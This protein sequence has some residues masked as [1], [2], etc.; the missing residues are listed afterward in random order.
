MWYCIVWWMVGSILKGHAVSIFRLEGL[1]GKM[2]AT[3]C[4]KTLHSHSCEDYKVSIWILSCVWCRVVWLLDETT[5]TPSVLELHLLCVLFG[6]HRP[7]WGPAAG[8]CLMS[9]LKRKSFCI[10]ECKCHSHWHMLACKY[11]FETK[12]CMAVAHCCCWLHAK[13]LAVPNSRAS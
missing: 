2:E 7:T 9:K 10:Y 3:A 4:C 13:I 11:F 1:K 8:I 5:D 6:C 12:F